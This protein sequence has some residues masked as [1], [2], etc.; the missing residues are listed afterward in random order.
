[1]SRKPRRNPHDKAARKPK[2]R[3]EQEKL[4]TAWHATAVLLGLIVSAL[5][6]L[7][8][9]L[10]GRTFSFWLTQQDYVRTELNVTSVDQ[11]PDA[12][13]MFGIVAA[14]GEE[15][16]VPRIPSEL[17]EYDSPSDPT[18]TRMP[19]EKAKGKQIAIWYAES[20]TSIWT[21]PR[22]QFVS[23]YPQPPDEREVLF[24]SVIA[25]GMLGL[26]VGAAVWGFRGASALESE[27]EPGE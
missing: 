10:A 16:R 11:G 27:Q 13:G 26:G 23:E 6:L 24:V 18:G 15:I 1:M 22:V 25:V 3:R 21:S 20:H 9:D 7:V 19:P 14:T 17:F 5:S 4:P 12:D 2:R 8:M